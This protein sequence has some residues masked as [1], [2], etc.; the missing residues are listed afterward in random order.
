MRLFY[1]FFLS[2]FIWERKK[3]FLYYM[4]EQKSFCAFCNI[5]YLVVYFYVCFCILPC[6]LRRISGSL[7]LPKVLNF[8]THKKVRSI[9]LKTSYPWLK[10]VP[11]VNF[12]SLVQEFFPGHSITF[13]AFIAI[14]S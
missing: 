3:S 4:E 1:S 10:V 13:L 5:K 7:E 11:V 2:L 8:E 14:G 6:F 9:E 12:M